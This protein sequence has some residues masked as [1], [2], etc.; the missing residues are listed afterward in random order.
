MRSVAVTGHRPNKLGWGYDYTEPHWV[1]LKERFKSFLLSEKITDAFSGMALGVDVVFAI[2]II[3]LKEAGY[4]IRL[5][6][7]I[8]C[9]NQCCKWTKESQ[10][11][12]YTLLGH[13]DEII[14]MSEYSET[15]Y[16]NLTLTRNNNSY[17][18][19]DSNS[20]YMY[21]QQYKPYLLQKRNIYMVDNNFDILAVWNGSEGGTANCIKYAISLGS[22]NVIRIDPLTV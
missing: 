11:L 7:I 12:Y 6:A 16:V 13:A 17:V 9:N 22:R 3:E 19:I 10:V 18:L 1:R 8:P 14:G 4:N 5:H 15:G 2:S 20:G 21:Q